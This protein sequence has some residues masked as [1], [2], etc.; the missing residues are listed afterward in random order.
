MTSIR[1]H[2]EKTTQGEIGAWL[3][4]I[5]Y[6]VLSLF[7]LIAGNM[8]NSKALI[9]DGMNN[10]T[11]I[12]ASVA[13]L[14][15]IK[16]AKRPADDD[17]P[18]GHRRAETIASLFA[19]FV[20]ATISIQVL[21]DVIID[22]LN[23]TPVTP[24]PIAAWCALISAIIMYFVYR[25]N[26]RLSKKIKSLALKAAAKDNLSDAWV[27]IGAGAG[28]LAAQWNMAWLDPIFALIIGCIIAKTAWG[29]FHESSHML[30]DGFNIEQLEAYQAHILTMD[31]VVEVTEMKGRMQG[32]QIFI[33]ATILVDSSL[34]IAEGHR[35][36]DQ[37]EW[38]MA[39][40]FD[41]HHVHIHVEPA[42]FTDINRDKGSD[43][44]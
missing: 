34:T 41:I 39:Q 44:V 5:A 17:H 32:N 27:S 8:S 14:I 31:G 33:E 3:S 30:T 13:V 21:M 36:S 18:Y 38:S 2:E 11:D 37:I 35:I 15:G 12:I 23:K 40:Y 24:D 25:Y 1:N 7:K 26:L 20:M 6:L 43:G 28:I 42:Y 16:I 19:S 9:A 29:I 10:V 22:L 4:I